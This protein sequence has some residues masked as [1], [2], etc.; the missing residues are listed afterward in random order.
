MKDHARY[1]RM[2]L[3]QAKIAFDR[4]DDP[5]GAVI[6]QDGA[7]VGAGGNRVISAKDMTAHAEMEAIRDSLGRDNGARLSAGVLYTTEEPCPMCLWMILKSGLPG[8]VIGA[9]YRDLADENIGE[10]RVEALLGLT[11]RTL[12][13]TD[14]VMTA[15][16][17]AAHA[18]K[19][20][21]E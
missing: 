7:V 1:M 10:Y 5:V 18:G 16:C 12:E 11:S 13:I 19:F 20:A 9:R 21:D 15:A 8:I 6:I 3:A 17:R 14:G 2:A 4:G